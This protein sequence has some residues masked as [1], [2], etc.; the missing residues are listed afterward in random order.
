VGENFDVWPTPKGDA[1]GNG[2]GLRLTRR[3]NHPS[4]SGLSGGGTDLPRC[5]A[6]AT[7]RGE[8]RPRLYIEVERREP[9][10][11]GDQATGVVRARGEVD[12]ETVDRFADILDYRLWSGCEGVLVD[13]SDVTFM[14]STGISALVRADRALGGEGLR[15]AVAAQPRSQVEGLLELTGLRKRFPRSL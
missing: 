6:M 8:G 11:N 15:L 4:L 9:A 10:T 2:A 12:L 5:H 3:S 14:D 7:P 13:L 1:D